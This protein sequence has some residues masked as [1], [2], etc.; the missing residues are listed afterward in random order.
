MRTLAPEGVDSANENDDLIIDFKQI[1]NDLY[2]K[3]ISRKVTA[4]VRQKQKDKGLKKTSE[5]IE[6]IISEGQIT[7]PQLRMLVKK[8]TVH[9]NE[10]S[11]LDIRFEMNGNWNGSYAVM[12]SGGKPCEPLWN[13]NPPPE[14]YEALLKEDLERER[15]GTLFSCEAHPPEL[16]EEYLDMLA[17]EAEEELKSEGWLE[18]LERK[19]CLEEA[20]SQK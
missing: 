12:I 13:E 16:D 11:T 7:D 14:F 19:Y 20:D 6:E 15:E 10:D 8:V 9:Q 4:G 1:V 17:A 2:C 18:E 3:D 5:V